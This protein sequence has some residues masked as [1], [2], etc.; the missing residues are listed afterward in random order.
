VES[1][2]TGQA[3]G[4]ELSGWRGRL[5]AHLE[6]RQVSR[7][8]YGSIIGLALVLT[9][10]AHPTTA[11]VAIGTLVATGLAV[12]LAEA[13]SEIVG[14]RVRTG[15]GGHPEPLGTVVTDTLAVG[16]GITFPAVFFLAAGA[17]LIEF[18]TA[19]SLAKWTG[20]GLIAAYGYLAARLS[21]S[22]PWGA[23]LQASGVAVI[24]AVLIAFKALLH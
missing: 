22:H 17:G 16:F 9:L 1:R 11:G 4:S 7:V 19:F 8:V 6:S 14:A 12:G 10:E 3:S 13:Y 20:L 23:L 5:A 18:D 15:V 2:T 21:G 24:A